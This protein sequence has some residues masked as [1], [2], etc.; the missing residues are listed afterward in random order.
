MKKF[1]AWLAEQDLPKRHFA[2]IAINF[3]VLYAEGGLVALSYLFVTS[4]AVRGSFL[5]FVGLVLAACLT[6]QIMTYLEDLMLSLRRRIQA[7]SQYQLPV[8]LI[9]FPP[10]IMGIMMASAIAS[11]NGTLLMIFAVKY[12][13]LMVAAIVILLRSAVGNQTD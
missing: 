12:S 11:G 6:V 7:G 10:I 13:V 5:C 8:S 1:V 2:L 4:V 3:V 9:D